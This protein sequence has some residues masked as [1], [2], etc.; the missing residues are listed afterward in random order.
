MEMKGQ[1]TTADT[2]K[3]YMLAG[4][5]TVTIRSIPTQMRYTFKIRQA[6]PTERNNWRTDQ[7]FVNLL[8]GQDNESD[9][10]YMGMIRKGIFQLTT[11]S[12]YNETTTP[13]KA[14]RWVFDRLQN[15]IMPDKLEIWH[16]GTCGR[17]G[18]KLTVPESVER[19][20]GPECAKHF[21]PKAA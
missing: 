14:F 18:R 12:K 21:M 3:A 19:G 7:Y 9:Y 17:C 4:N 15:G 16:E 2:A 5:A 11:A 13:V 6:K 1:L 20:I 10:A 8:I